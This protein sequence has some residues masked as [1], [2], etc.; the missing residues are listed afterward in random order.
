MLHYDKRGDVVAF[1][2]VSTRHR[3]LPEPL[4]ALTQHLEKLISLDGELS[5][6]HL[7]E[8]PRQRY[9]FSL[10]PERGASGQPAGR[11]PHISTRLGGEVHLALEEP[12]AGARECVR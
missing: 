3:D 4:G 2:R 6:E 8:G 10:I 7:G 9:R 12:P 1:D 5:A 11:S